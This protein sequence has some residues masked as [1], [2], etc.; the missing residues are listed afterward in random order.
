MPQDGR[1]VTEYETGTGLYAW[2]MDGE[3]YHR[4]LAYAVR[5]D[6]WP[7][8]YWVNT[9]VTRYA[10]TGGM[11]HGRVRTDSVWRNS[12]CGAR[13]WALGGNGHRHRGHSEVTRVAP[14][15]SP[16]HWRALVREHQ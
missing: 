15:M 4:R 1:M 6:G 3:G 9:R 2:V 8:A 12:L 14:P 16:L 10:G 11:V 5:A 13:M 7:R